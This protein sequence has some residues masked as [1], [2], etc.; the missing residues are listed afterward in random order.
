MEINQ[1]T[2]K[3]R[4]RIVK[5]QIV[6]VEYDDSE[7]LPKFNHILT[8]PENEKVRLEVYAYSDHNTLLC[9]SLSS[10]NV[11]Y[12]NMPIISTNAPISIPVGDNILGRVTNIFGEPQDNKG[13]ITDV[14]FVP[15]Y[16]DKK[17]EA[18]SK[19]KAEVLETGIKI[20]D[21]FTPFV[22]G[23]KIGF[24]GGAGVGK[25][26]IMTE[27]LSNITYKHEGVAV[28]AGIGE[29]IREGHGL[30]LDLEKS[31]VLSRVAMIFGQMN[32]NAIIRFRIAWAGATL[33]EYFRDEQKKDVLFFADNVY[34]FV[35]AGM[36]VS[37]A[38]G[39]IPSELGYQATLETEVADFENRL[40]VTDNGS[41]TSIQNVYVPAD[42][43]TDIGVLTITTQ[44]DAVVILSR[45]LASLGFYP[46]VDV[47]ASSAKTLNKSF[48][49]ERHYQIAIQAIQILQQYKRLSRIVAIIGES[50]LS[51][52]DQLIYQRAK[53]L[54]N[55][56]TQPFFTTESQTGKKGA[57]VNRDTCI[58]DVE[59]IITGKLDSVDAEK[60][61]YIGSLNEAKLMP[62]EEKISTG[63]NEPIK[64]DNN[65]QKISEAI[66]TD[67]NK[68]KI[69]EVKK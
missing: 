20:V 13:P 12:R 40:S 55:Y 19:V 63:N 44:L 22:K 4:V 65:D 62:T 48:V 50:E 46:P 11:L 5:G 6:E 37:S 2:F 51:P 35:Q 7:N 10:R 38:L 29:R 18:S 68:T 33:A 14:K 57:Y 24:I 1:N 16:S 60:F 26:T 21:F 56:M 8:S 15:I 67:Q 41:I 43:M 54:T 34:R 31:K 25:T 28:F 49:G 53:K 17:M 9:L 66:P 52:Y 47:L 23:G 42:D 27:L 32:D 61:M 39:S 58:N 59:A 69:D 30:M 64:N 36:E 3:G 45:P